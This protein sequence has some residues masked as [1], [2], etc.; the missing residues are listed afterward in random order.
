MKSKVIFTKAEQEL[1]FPALYQHTACALVV[2]F[3]N[4]Y[5]GTVVVS[6]DQMTPVGFYTNDWYHCDESTEWIRLPDGTKVE[7]EQGV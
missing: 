3:T 6:S 1:R 4:R 2:L 5:T 7:I